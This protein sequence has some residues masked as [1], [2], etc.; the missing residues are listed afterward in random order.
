[1]TTVFSL[2]SDKRI[3]ETFYSRHP[4]LSREVEELELLGIPPDTLAGPIPVGAAYVIFDEHGLSSSAI[5]AT[6][7]KA[8]GYSSSSSPITKA[9]PAILSRGHRNSAN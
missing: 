6:A 5:P 9:S 4:L 8:R 3:E 2:I 1:M 7:R